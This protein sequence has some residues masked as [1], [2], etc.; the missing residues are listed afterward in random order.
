MLQMTK[1]VDIKVGDMLRASPQGGEVLSVE[2]CEVTFH[3]DASSEVTRR[4]SG[5][6]ITT[7]QGE[8]RYFDD[9]ILA[10]QVP[11]K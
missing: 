1:A 4:G 10:I 7:A 5:V 9:D 6:K 2:P 11:P 3:K 8:R